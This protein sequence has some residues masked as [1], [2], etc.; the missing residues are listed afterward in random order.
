MYDSK[1]IVVKVQLNQSDDL[2]LPICT[3][4]LN[5][6]NVKTFEIEVYK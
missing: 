2:L 6:Y 1:V 4:Q 3:E 5:V